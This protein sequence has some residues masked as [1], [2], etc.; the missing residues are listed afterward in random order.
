MEIGFFCIENG[1]SDETCSLK[2]KNSKNLK[3]FM[4]FDV[5]EGEHFH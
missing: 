2:T 5:D 1:N 3:F 4:N